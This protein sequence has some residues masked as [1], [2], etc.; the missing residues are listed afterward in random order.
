MKADCAEWY[1][2]CLGFL[3]SFFAEKV[4]VFYPEAREEAVISQ[5]PQEEG[6][7]FVKIKM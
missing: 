5:E 1:Y 6:W 3:H 4:E 7:D 2:F